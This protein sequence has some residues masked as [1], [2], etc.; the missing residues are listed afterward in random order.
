MDLYHI[1]KRDIHL[2]FS[3]LRCH[4]IRQSHALSFLHEFLLYI[5]ALSGGFRTQSGICASAKSGHECW[6]LLMSIF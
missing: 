4:M 5:T 1:D 6:F 3:V 2:S